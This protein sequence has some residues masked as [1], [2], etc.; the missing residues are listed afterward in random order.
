MYST[1]PAGQ[2]LWDV[3]YDGEYV[4]GIAQKSHYYTAYDANEAVIGQY[5]NL[6]AAGHAVAEADQQATTEGILEAFGI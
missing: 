2:G 6:Q 1:T 5:D 4:G 3:T